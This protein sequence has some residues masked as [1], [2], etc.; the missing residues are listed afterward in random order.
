MNNP[1]T[2]GRD[3]FTNIKK[4]QPKVSEENNLTGSA[5]NSADFN[6]RAEFRGGNKNV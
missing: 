5:A 3:I 1:F 4:P 6:F 2:S